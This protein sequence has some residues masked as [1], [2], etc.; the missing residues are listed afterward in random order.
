MKNCIMNLELVDLMQVCY[1]DIK[2]LTSKRSYAL[3][4]ID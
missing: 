2:F 1:F 4:N 3:Q